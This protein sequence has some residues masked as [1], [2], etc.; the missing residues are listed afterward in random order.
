MDIA[1]KD[2]DKV[3]EF[4]ARSG[5]NA[6]QLAGGEPTLHPKFDEILLKI[7]KKGIYGV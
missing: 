2:L 7:L 4:L 6:L 5:C 1:M 3:L